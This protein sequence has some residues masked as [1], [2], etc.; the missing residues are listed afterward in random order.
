MTRLLAVGGAGTSTPV[1]AGTAWY[2]QTMSLAG[3]VRSAVRVLA[4]LFVVAA[5]WLVAPA[6][7]AQDGDGAYVGDQPEVLG[8][9]LEA[10][11]EQQV[12]QVQRSA[13]AQV[14]GNAL[15][16]TG[17]DVAVLSALGAGAVTAGALV[18][19]ARR[20]HATI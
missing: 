7:G 13:E 16:F 15:A 11:T 4:V 14:A 20:R 18:L 12:A 17:S 2:G 1:H 3:S 10:P 6:A 8:E 9:Q 5:T 19:L